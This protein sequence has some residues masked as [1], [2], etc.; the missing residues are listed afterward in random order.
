LTAEQCAAEVIG[1]RVQILLNDG[2][3]MMGLLD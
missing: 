2:V 1:R 3:V